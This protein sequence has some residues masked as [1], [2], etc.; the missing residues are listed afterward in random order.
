[1]S[2][3]QR[4]SG[5]KENHCHSN[6]PK[7]KNKEFSHLQKQQNFRCEIGWKYQMWLTLLCGEVVSCCC[8]FV[9]S[10]F[11]FFCDFLLLL[12]YKGNWQNCNKSWGARLMYRQ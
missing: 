12:N 9:G 3:P 4:W 5:A 2:H 6:E 10:D 7:D 8:L 11:F 1:L